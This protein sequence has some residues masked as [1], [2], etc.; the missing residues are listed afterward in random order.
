MSTEG[1][2][3]AVVAAMIAN[4]GIALTK[5]AAFLVTGSS[6]MLSEAIHSVADTGNQ[7]LLL[8][9]GRRAGRAPDRLRPFGYGRTRY[10]YAFVVAIILFMLGGLFS[11]Y[12]GFHKITHPEEL[13]RAW[14]A[15]LVL[16]VS[17]ALE[18]WSFRT[19]VR[20]AN[21]SRGRRSL[22]QYVRDARQ[23]ELPVV[24]LEDAG[25]LVGLLLAMLGIS[26]A[27]VTGDPRWDGVG[28]LAIGTLLLVIAVFL[29]FE[30]A[31]LLIGESAMPDQERAIGDAVRSVPGIARII[32]MR[33]LHT[34]PDELLV[35]VKVAVAPEVTVGALA[36]LIDTAEAAL[37]AAV[38]Q[39]RWVYMEPDVDRGSQLGS[40]PDAGAGTTA[41]Q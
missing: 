14:I 22:L 18:G 10:V 19:A 24:L 20:E 11:L 37:R 13:E 34:G 35:G 3:R 29:A 5:F 12:E 15:Y 27:L 17:I 9:G 16:G 31:S 32:H 26:L 8:L 36:S 7:G 38:P 33:T 41:A 21:R 40:G 4:S 23:P 6:S 1:G 25:A 39:A 28:A 2:T 30:V